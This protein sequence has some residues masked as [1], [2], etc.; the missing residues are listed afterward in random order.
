MIYIPLFYNKNRLVTKLKKLLSDKA[1]LI[2]LIGFV[3][4]QIFID[5]Y[6]VFFES[7]Y[8]I[9][10]ISLPEIINIG[11]ISFL[12][13]IFFIKNFKKPKHY[14]PLVIYLFLFFT[15]CVFHIINILNFNQNI[16]TNSELNWV[17]E[18]Y[19]IVRTYIIPV[20]LCYYFLFSNLTLSFFKKTVSL[21]SLIISLNIILTNIFKVSF[22]C[23]ASTLEKN[24][25]ISR[26]FFEWFFNPDTEFPVYMTSKGWFYMGN[27]IGL[28]LF[29]LFVFVL[30]NA[31]ESGKIKDYLLVGLNGLALV[32]IGTKVAS[33]GCSILLW[34]GIIIAFIF[35]V[36]LKQFPFKPTKR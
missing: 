20:L 27:Q 12:T 14:I 6:R 33:L 25:F 3:L 21:I 10:G 22:I 24:S 28:I 18:I 26:N 32:L 36:W 4:L 17:K 34:A 13:A 29:M 19:F 5:M 23:Y 7:K 2:E 30:M 15:Y 1:F 35:G 8:Q 16:L 31:F 9:F 11:Y